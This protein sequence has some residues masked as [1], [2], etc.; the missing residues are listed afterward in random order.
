[1]WLFGKILPVKNIPYLSLVIFEFYWS[2]GQLISGRWRYTPFF[3]NI[4]YLPVCRLQ[5][6]I[7][8]NVSEEP[9][10]SNIY[11]LSLVKS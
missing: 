11:Q 6:G 5:E 2:G 9:K 1:M 7:Y 10:I 3:Q 8:A 4:F